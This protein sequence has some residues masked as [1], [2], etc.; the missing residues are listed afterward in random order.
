V[1][2]GKKYSE[3]ADPCDPLSLPSSLRRS[4]RGLLYQLAPRSVVSDLSFGLWARRIQGIFSKTR[5]DR[6]VP[7]RGSLV[8]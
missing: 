5:Y 7:A 2:R 4:K 8:Y 3:T 1:V 6:Y